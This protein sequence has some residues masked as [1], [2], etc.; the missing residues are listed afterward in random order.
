MRYYVYKCIEETEALFDNKFKIREK[1]SMYKNVLNLSRKT[2]YDY[3]KISDLYYKLA[4]S[5]YNKSAKQLIEKQ[6]EILNIMS[7]YMCDDYSAIEILVNRELEIKR[8]IESLCDCVRNTGFSISGIMNWRKNMGNKNNNTDTKI[9]EDPLEKDVRKTEA[10]MNRK[11]VEQLIIEDKCDGC[12]G[13]DGCVEN[14]IE[15]RDCF[16]EKVIETLIDE[17]TETRVITKDK[18]TISESIFSNDNITIP[19]ADVMFVEKRDSGIMLIMKNTTWNMEA[20]CW[21]NNAWISNHDNQAEK[22]M[23]DWCYYRHELEGGKNV[24]VH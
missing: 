1:N 22:F 5:G 11:E 8:V 2:A 24:F 3:E 6:C 10:N 12:E 13:F 15:K 7:I 9:D 16:M 20:D 4:S 21:A 19:M 18:V 23:Q 17:S 14:N